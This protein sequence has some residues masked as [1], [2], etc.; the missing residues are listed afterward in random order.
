MPRNVRANIELG[1]NVAIA[2]AVV[3]I[4]GVVV[5]RYLF[6]EQTNPRS[7][8]E[9]KQ[10][11]MNSRIDVPNVNRNQNGSSLVFFLDKDCAYCTSSA[12]FYRQL[13]EEVA[14]RNVNSLAIL[15]NSIDEARNY[16][17]SLKLPIENV[18][19]ASLASYNI[20]GTPTVLL[21]DHEGIVKNVWLGAMRGREKQMQ[22][23]LMASLDANVL[24]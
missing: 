18:R 21:L 10:A 16:L 22:D 17:Q 19:S 4:A 1:L 5:K 2:I 20:P 11:L 14:K 8:Q 15:P 7:M 24:K 12:P 6:T 3:V 23:E 9:Y 13:L